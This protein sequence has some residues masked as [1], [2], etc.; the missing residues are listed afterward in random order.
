MRHHVIHRRRDQS[1]EMSFR[2]ADRERGQRRVGSTSAQDPLQ[3]GHTSRDM[4][5]RRRRDERRILPPPL[6]E[7]AP[8]KWNFGRTRTRSFRGKRL[9]E[10]RSPRK[11]LLGVLL[12]LGIGACATNRGAQGPSTNTNL[13]SQE[14]IESAHQPNLFDV[15]RALRPM[16]L[17]QY[18]ATVQSGQDAG[19]TVYVDNQRVG[20]VEVLREMTTTTATSLRFYSA[21]EA[22]S[23]F[24]L[25]NLHGVIQVTTA[26]GS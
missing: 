1:A 25:G 7:L 10:L 6:P 22:Q 8:V 17:R 12:T 20:G 19:V 24:G 21:S 3:V 9:V 15:V 14:E 26:R 23:R 4:L 5:L 18:S 16:W 11:A 13:L 2:S